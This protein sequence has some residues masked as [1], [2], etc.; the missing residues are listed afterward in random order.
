METAQSR[1]LTDP[2]LSDPLFGG[3]VRHEPPRAHRLEDLP[4]PDIVCITHAHFDHFHEDTLRRLPKDIPIVI[5]RSPIR[6]IRAE[7]KAL[8]FKDVRELKA[9]KSLTFRDLKITAIPSVGIP[10]E[11]AYVFEGEGCGVFDAAD[12]VFEPIAAELGRRFKLD[13][14]FIPFCGWDYSG[15]LGLDPEKK[16]KPDYAE[17]AKAC[18]EMG[19]QY[20]VPAASNVYWYPEEL[21]WLNDRVCPGKPEEFLEIIRNAGEGRMTP[22]PMNPGDRWIHDGARVVPAPK[23]AVAEDTP[24]EGSDWKRWLRDPRLKRY[25][26]AGLTKVMERFL[27]QRRRHLLKT[28]PLSPKIIL[29]LLAT[30]FEISSLYEGKY[31]FWDINLKRW[32]PVKPGP[33]RPSAQF[34]LLVEWDDL[35]ALFDGIVDSQDLADACRMKMFYL[36]K[37]EN[38]W[39]IFCMEFIFFTRS[40][41]RLSPKTTG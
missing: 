16:W 40:I 6:N 24:S 30:H 1:C 33:H 13:I 9:W 11:V 4:T 36:P 15:L 28:L 7:L 5:P 39:R 26:M 27:R 37:R 21:K 19:L 31:V 18:V 14:G 20:V 3:A 29:T 38:Y 12:C 35:C 34:G 41:A 32:N 2:W 23:N 25:D 10:E 8:G 17:V 22:V